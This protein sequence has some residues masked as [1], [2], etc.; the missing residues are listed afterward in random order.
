[1]C[2]GC[3]KSDE[4]ERKDAL[5]GM[6][7]ANGTMMIAG[8][9]IMM[10][11]T[12]LLLPSGNVTDKDI[13]QIEE[14]IESS[15]LCYKALD[16]SPKNMKYLKGWKN[17]RSEAKDLIEDALD[18]LKDYKGIIEKAKKKKNITGDIEDYNDDIKKYE[19]RYRKLEELQKKL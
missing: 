4:E 10:Q 8:A 16:G 9:P 14:I 3:G 15:K 17:F 11:R 12:L 13:K 18:L 7:L 6:E 5:A 19:K 1:M 2:F